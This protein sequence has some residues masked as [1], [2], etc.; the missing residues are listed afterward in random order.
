MHIRRLHAKDYDLIDALHLKACNE[1]AKM[2]A[3]FSGDNP[4]K[5]DIVLGAFDHDHLIGAISVECLAHEYY[6]KKLFVD[7][8][9]QT[10]LD[11]GRR[12]LNIGQKLMQ[13]MIAIADADNIPMTL[14][15][16]IQND[17]A[18]HIYQKLGFE[19]EH[20]MDD[21]TGSIDMRREP[22]RFIPEPNAQIPAPDLL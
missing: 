3:K 10:K 22:N 7:P 20:L 6:V 2:V 15:V 4:D 17:A 12:P 19:R 5:H 9:Y 11:S 21:N 8:A 16:E 14:I 18:M 1:N 13:S